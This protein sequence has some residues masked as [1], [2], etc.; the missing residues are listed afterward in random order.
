MT[1]WFDMDGT[2][3]NL[4]GEENWLSDIKAEKTTPYDNAKP[5]INMEKFAYLCDWL[6]NFGVNIGIISWVAKNG[7]KQYNLAV[8]NAKKEWLSRNCNIDFDKIIITKYGVNKN[9]FAHENDII[10]DD[11]ERVRNKWTHG[12][13]YNPQTVDINEKLAEI[14]ERVA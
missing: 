1:I 6:Q 8:E 14:L 11:D 2:I 13:S 5:M 3:A 10:F 12:F 9:K 7:K 4:Y